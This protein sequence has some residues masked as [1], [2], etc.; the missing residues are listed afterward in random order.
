MGINDMMHPGR[1]IPA[2]LIERY[3]AEFDALEA[4]RGPREYIRWAMP[5]TR[6]ADQLL[7]LR[8]PARREYITAAEYNAL[9]DA[10]V[11]AMG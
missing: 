1:P 2:E 9:I 11:E 5:V 4:R 7:S 10:I 6:A 8:L 3:G